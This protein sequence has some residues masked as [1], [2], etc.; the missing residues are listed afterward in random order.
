MKERI[1]GGEELGEVLHRDAQRVDGA[2]KVA[3]VLAV[4]PLVAQQVHYG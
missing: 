2:E 1:A 4:V 3:G